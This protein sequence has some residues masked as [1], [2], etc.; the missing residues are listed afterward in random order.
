MEKSTP[1]IPDISRLF[2]GAR[3]E[4]EVET[5]FAKNGAV[6]PDDGRLVAFAAEEDLPRARLSCAPK[7]WKKNPLFLPNGHTSSLSTRQKREPGRKP[8]KQ[9]G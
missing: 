5:V 2:I 9:E 3:N 8:K 6:S 1:P 7:T 4:F